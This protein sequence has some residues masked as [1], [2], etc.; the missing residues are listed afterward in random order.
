MLSR[1]VDQDASQNVI[2]GSSVSSHKVHDALLF[3]LRAT[4]SYPSP[5]SSDVSTR[6][7][8]ARKSLQTPQGPFTT[9]HYKPPAI[10]NG[11]S[12]PCST[13]SVDSASELN[14]SPPVVPN[15]PLQSTDVDAPSECPLYAAQTVSAA[16]GWNSIQPVARGSRKGRHHTSER[17]NELGR[18]VEIC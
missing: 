18:D 5:T 13:P 2:D 9:H 11:G 15:E 17:R 14:E 10:Y 12:E 7:P 3:G 16:L 8:A 4:L 1:W 6:S